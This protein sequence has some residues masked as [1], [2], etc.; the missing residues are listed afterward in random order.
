M[1]RLQTLK[2]VPFEGGQMHFVRLPGD[3]SA[4]A[5]LMAAQVELDGKR[6][7]VRMIE[8][9]RRTATGTEGRTVGLVV[10]PVY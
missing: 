4:P 2:S 1:H 7:F 3:L 9:A 8:D 10:S 6:V 5:W